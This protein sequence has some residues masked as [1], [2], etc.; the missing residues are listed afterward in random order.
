MSNVGAIIMGVFAALWW[1]VGVRV[2]GHASPLTYGI[3]IL[4]T[5]LIVV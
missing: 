2:S 4:V 5:G 1:L 3:P